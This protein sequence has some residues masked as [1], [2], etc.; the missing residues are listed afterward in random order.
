MNQ[1]NIENQIA[2]ARRF[3]LNLED[4]PAFGAGAMAAPEERTFA[5]LAHLF[6]LI[7]WPWKRKV[8]PAVDAHGKEALNFAITALIIL[9]P[10]GFI[11]GLCG[12]TVARIVAL[13]TSVLSLGLLALV[14]CA[15]IQAGKGKLLRYPINFRFIK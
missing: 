13:G 4:A 8:S 10:I 7:I 14:I 2:Q 5:M 11:A 15:M 9:W 3:H 1:T 6:P 12:V